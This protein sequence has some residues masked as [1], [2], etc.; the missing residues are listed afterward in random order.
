MKILFILGMHRSGTSCLAHCLENMGSNFVLNKLGPTKYQK[1]LEYGPVTQINDEILR[2]W[3]FP[4]LNQ[5]LFIKLL[6]RYKIKKFLKDAH[7]PDSSYICLKDPRMVLTFDYWIRCASEYKMIGIY[8]RPGEVIR[9]FAARSSGYAY[10]DENHSS[11]LWIMTNKKL[12]ELQEQ[13]QFPL[14]SFNLRKQEFGT[15]LQKICKHLGVPFTQEGFN[16]TFT[17]KYR[18][19]DKPN[20]DNEFK[21]VYEELEIRADKFFSFL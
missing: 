2:S 14:I 21:D 18:H 15:R 8:R 9:S 13:F 12:C 4:D 16:Q 10:L 20:V 1:H 17:E 3:K 7:N 6:Y 11:N 5:G 19:H